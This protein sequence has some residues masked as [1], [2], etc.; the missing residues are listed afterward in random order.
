MPPSAASTRPGWS[1]TAPVNAPARV[2]EELARQQLLR[3]RRA[4]DVTNGRPRRAALAWIGA[5]Q[6]ALAGAALAAEQHRRV[7]WRRR[8]ARRPAPRASAARRCEVRRSGDL[9]GQPPLEVG[10]LRRQAPLPAD[11]LEQVADLRRRER[12]GQVVPGAAAHRLD[13]GLDGGVGGDEDDA[14]LASS[15]SSL[16]MRSSPLSSARARSTKARSRVAVRAPRAASPVPTATPIRGRVLPA[17]RS[18]G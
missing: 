8:A 7:G 15:P 14:R 5:R 6:H 10:H 3:Q 12:L 16:G 1:R 18:T 2:A 17:G 11:A 9:V 13:G 4:V